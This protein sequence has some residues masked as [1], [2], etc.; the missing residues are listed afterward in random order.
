MAD[1]ALASV[2]AQTHEVDRVIVVDDASRE[3][4]HPPDDDVTLVRNPVS[5]GVCAARN[6]ALSLTTTDLVMFLDDDDWLGDDF[7]AEQVRGLAQTTL[8][9]PVAGIGTRVFV[10]GRRR[11]S[12]LGRP[13]L[14]QG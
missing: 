9:A 5:V 3:P 1:R 7:I 12:P 4:Y 14:R 10:G 2:R 11:R 6:R 13:L 8:P